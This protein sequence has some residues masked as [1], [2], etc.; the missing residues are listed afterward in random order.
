MTVQTQEIPCIA[1]KN[2]NSDNSKNVLVVRFPNG[3]WSYGGY[4]RSYRE[5]EE[6]EFFW[7]QIPSR[8]DCKTA[9]PRAQAWRRRQQNKQK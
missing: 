5:Y 8:S 4:P 6:I 3:E 1:N 7:V 2:L 9:V